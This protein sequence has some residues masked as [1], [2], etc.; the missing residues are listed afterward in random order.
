[1]HPPIKGR[2]AYF[3]QGKFKASKASPAIN[4]I[5]VM[6]TAPGL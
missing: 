2:R 5:N 6:S 1:M 3:N 4:R